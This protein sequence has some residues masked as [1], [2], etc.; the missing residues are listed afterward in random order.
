MGMAGTQAFSTTPVQKRASAGAP[1]WLRAHGKEVVSV[2]C[3]PLRSPGTLSANLGSLS[4][5]FLIC[6]GKTQSEFLKAWVAG[7]DLMGLNG[8]L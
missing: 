8:Q 1:L 6:L 3:V 2:A 4:L 7:G 5:C